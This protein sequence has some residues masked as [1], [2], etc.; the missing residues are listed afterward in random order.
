MSAREDALAALRAA[1]AAALP[2]PVQRNATVPEALP[3]AGYATLQ[4]GATQDTLAMMSPLRF[5]V[6]HRAELL[7]MV[8]GAD[9]AARAAALDALIVTATT[10]VT[11]APLLGG[12]TEWA[13]PEAPE[14]DHQAG[15]GTSIVAGALLP[16]TLIF[17]AA[18]S[19]AG[20]P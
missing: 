19:P 20:E 4:D 7:L 6:T 15:V 12:A 14:I 18:G 13:Q 10:A 11:A 8:P 1:L 3:P 17:T 16:I 2:I 9:D 5:Q